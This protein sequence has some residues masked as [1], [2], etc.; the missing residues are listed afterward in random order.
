MAVDHAHTLS[1]SSSLSLFPSFSITH[2]HTRTHSSSHAPALS[3]CVYHGSCIRAQQFAIKLD[4]G[5]RIS[6]ITPTHKDSDWHFRKCVFFLFAFRFF[7][8]LEV[9]KRWT[10]KRSPWLSSDIHE[11]VE[12]F[13]GSN[14]WMNTSSCILVLYKDLGYKNYKDNA[15]PSWAVFY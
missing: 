5:G 8:R 13:S 7:L 9:G 2:K 6:I 14:N 12:E 15:K 10:T 11:I 4:F 3:L 1:L